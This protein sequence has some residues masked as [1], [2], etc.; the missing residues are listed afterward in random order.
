M[1]N[2]GKY[3]KLESIRL[4]LTQ[5]VCILKID[6]YYSHSFNHNCFEQFWQLKVFIIH[7]SIYFYFS[8]CIIVRKKKSF[9]YETF[10]AMVPK[11]DDNSEIG[12]HAK[13]KLVI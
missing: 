12:A 7:M 9:S 4:L 6:F 11:S 13:M 1:P 8:Q 10:Y 2:Y 5:P 3:S